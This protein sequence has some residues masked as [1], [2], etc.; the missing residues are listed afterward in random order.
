MSN[1]LA[2]DKQ[3]A[4]LHH[5][6]E[7]NSIRATSRLC[8]VHRNTVMRHLVEFG[9]GCQ[10]FMDLSFENLSLSHL[11]I[12]EIW[13]FVGKKQSKLTKDERHDPL[14]TRGDAYL[15]IA[16]DEDTKLIP[17]YVLG[18]RTGA[19]AAKLA[20]MLAERLVR[21]P[22]GHDEVAISTDGFPGYPAAIG[23]A[24]GSTARHGVLIKQYDHPESGRYAPPRLIGTDRINI[25]N[26]YDLDTVC[27]SHVE[28]T[29][30]TIRT[31]M[32]R[33]TRLALGFSKKIENLHAAVRL[34][35]AYYNFCWQPREKG[36]SGRLRSTPAMMAGLTNRVWR[37]EELCENVKGLEQD[38]LAA[39]RYAKLRRRLFDGNGA[40]GTL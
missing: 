40:G 9:E 12:D 37:F 11:Q 35:L 38:R 17:G 4:I 21:R 32:R 24:F 7:G 15:F 10:N 14:T 30:L 19:N 8:R 27:T 39:E 5:L 2:T 22:G 1:H 26:V 29:N 3:V 16:L 25:Q 31:F 34:H 28:R 36:R 6:A 18:K 13:T 20:N 33:F 23:N